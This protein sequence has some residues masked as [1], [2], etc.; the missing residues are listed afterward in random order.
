MA[1]TFL[2]TDPELDSLRSTP[3]FKDLAHHVGLPTANPTGA[4][5]DL[6]PG[7]KAR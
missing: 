7:A 4:K 5:A 1:L 6:S 3:R 2:A